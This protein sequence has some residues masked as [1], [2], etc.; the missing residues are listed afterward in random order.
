MIRALIKCPNCESE[1]GDI[2]NLAQYMEDGSLS[3]RTFYKNH[4]GEQ[5]NMYIQG[6]EFDLIC[7]RCNQIAFRK[8]PVLI[9]QTT[10]LLFGTV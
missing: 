6:K 9:Q 2:L 4:K 10:T 7:G 5:I 1:T 3:I 8:T